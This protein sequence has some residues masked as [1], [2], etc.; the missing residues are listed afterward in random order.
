MKRTSH[1]ALVLNVKSGVLPLASGCALSCKFCSRWG[2][3]EGALSLMPV[4]RRKLF[5]SLLSMLRPYGTGRSID[6]GGGLYGVAYG[7][8]CINPFFLDYLEVLVE[9]LP[10]CTLNFSTSGILPVDLARLGTLKQ[11][12]RAGGG[13]I[14]IQV[15]VN[16]LDPEERSQIF[17]NRYD[18]MS[19]L[20]GW[21]DSG[22]VEKVGLFYFLDLEKTAA[23]IARIQKRDPAIGIHLRRV[24]WTRHTRPGGVHIAR[25]SVAGW[26]RAAAELATRFPRIVL[27]PYV[28]Q[29]EPIPPAF[30]DT[31]E[32]I[33]AH[34]PEHRL[35]CSE[36]VWHWFSN[37]YAAE[38]SRFIR[39]GNDA[40][41]GSIVAAGLL[42]FTD[43][44][45]AIEAGGDGPDRTYYLPDI[46]LTPIGDYDSLGASLQELRASVSARIELVPVTRLLETEQEQVLHSIIEAVARARS[47]TTQ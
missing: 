29:S 34:G 46:M 18:S 7:E 20:L 9:R 21:L 43:I 3:P 47:A 37:T 30:R 8:P 38:R 5:F 40:Y 17:C 14:S 12:A 27:S 23:S 2:N 10:G 13:Q 15:S 32:S 33:L 45:Q 16:S 6:L 1:E 28:M 4:L 35:I 36:S 25:R 39:V 26:L 44:R 31:I 24:D 41:G 22:L 19:T 42:T 11:R